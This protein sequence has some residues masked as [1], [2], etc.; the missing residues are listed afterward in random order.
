MPT[1]NITGEQATTLVEYF[2]ALSKDDSQTLGKHLAPV[3]EY[4]TNAKATAKPGEPAGA[5]WFVKD[6][7]AGT[8][9]AL[10]RWALE[11]KLVRPG[12]VDLLANSPKDLIEAHAKMTHR[13]E[14]LQELYDVEYP[15]VEPSAAQQPDARFKLGE[16]FT[17]DM[18]CLKCHVLGPMLPGPAKNTDDFVQMYRL[19]G[20]RGEGEQAVAILNGMPY[21]VGSA[22]DG[23]KLISVSVKVYDTGDVDTKAVVEGPSTSGETE[24][25]LLVAASAPNLALTHQRLREAWV[26]DWM[27]DPQAI[28]PGTKMPQNFAD[29]KSPFHDDQRYSGEN[30][31]DLLVDYLYD[32]GRRNARIPLPKVPAPKADEEFKEAEEFVD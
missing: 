10:R 22:I 30:H 6:Q 23:H 32:A 3:E 24:R 26:H 20:V 31:I 11:R 16:Q 15:F 17:V 5:D 12:E 18:G 25:V 4:V 14:F 7:F 13:V 19:D 29:G 28:M 8:A 9:E 21:P 2:A 27:L 1:F